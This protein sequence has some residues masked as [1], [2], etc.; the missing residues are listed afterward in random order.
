MIRFLSLLIKRPVFLQNKS[1]NPIYNQGQLTSIFNTISCGL[2]SKAANNELIRQAHIRLLKK[3]NENVANHKFDKRWHHEIR[4][5]GPPVTIAPG[6]PILWSGSGETHI[7]DR[8]GLFWPD[9]Q[10]VNVVLHSKKARTTES[11]NFLLFNFCN[12]CFFVEVSNNEIFD[13]R[14]S[15]S[16]FSK[17]C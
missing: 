9:D 10:I 11:L 2:Q 15:Y 3:A 13:F 5:R 7:W 4:H 8:Y 1:S 17:F 16:C 12:N 14:T 6:P